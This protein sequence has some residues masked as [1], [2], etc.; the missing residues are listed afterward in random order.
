MFL[1]PKEARKIGQAGRQ[2]LMERF[3]IEQMVAGVERVYDEIFA[4]G[5]VDLY[6]KGN[7]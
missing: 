2:R 5:D 6:I 3:S 1:N 4:N 7:N